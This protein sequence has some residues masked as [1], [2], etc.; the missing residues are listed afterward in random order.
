MKRHRSAKLLV[1]L[2]CVLLWTALGGSAAGAAAKGT[3]R[4]W[5]AAGSGTSTI[6]VVNGSVVV[7]DEGVANAAHLGKM[8]TQLVLT[9]TAPNCS[10]GTSTTVYTAANGDTVLVSGVITNGVK[11]NTI[12]GGTGR[13]EGATGSFTVTSSNIAP[14]PGHPE[15]FTFD[16]VHSGTIS[17]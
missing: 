11:V 17:Y 7:T 6:S 14:V 9:C 13:F 1:P 5:K 8:T 16:F 2:V 3:D 12:T 10:S 15:Q 4:P